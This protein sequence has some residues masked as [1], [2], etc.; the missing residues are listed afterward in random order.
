MRRCVG[1]HLRSINFT[2]PLGEK[3]DHTDLISSTGWAMYFIDGI[4]P[5]DKVYLKLQIFNSKTDILIDEYFFMFQKSYQTTL[6][7]RSYVTDPDPGGENRQRW[8]VDGTSR[9]GIE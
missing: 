1:L 4:F 9:S 3:F 6:D 7:A 5:T 2:K 8:Y